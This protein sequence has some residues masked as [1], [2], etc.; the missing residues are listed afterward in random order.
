MKKRK[1]ILDE[2]EQEIEDNIGKMEPT[3][4]FDK[5]KKMAELAAKKHFQD[6]QQITLSVAKNDVEAIKI[7]ADKLGVPYKAY[8]NMLIDQDVATI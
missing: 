1:I 2:Y 4:N 3:P 8:I 6:K 5:F 7:K